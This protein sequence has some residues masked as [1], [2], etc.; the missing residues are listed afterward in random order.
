MAPTQSTI[1]RPLS[2]EGLHK[3]PSGSSSYFQFISPYGIQTPPPLVMQ[4]PSQSLFYQGGSS[5]QH[6]QPEQ[7]QPQPEVKPRRNLAHNLRPP[8]CGTNFDHHMH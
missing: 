5:S 7:L 4:T 6:P 1:Y 2:Q 3:A 8:L